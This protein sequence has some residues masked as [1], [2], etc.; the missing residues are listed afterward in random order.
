MP[1]QRRHIRGQEV[2]PP[3]AAQQQRRVLSCGDDP[4]RRVGA[5]DTQRIGSL[6]PGE[7]LVHR[8]EHVAALAIIPGQQLG[9]HL[10]IRLGHE[11]AALLDQLLLQPGEI[12]D[13]TVVHHGE[14]S[15]AA[16]LRMGVHLIGLAVSSPPGV[17]DAHCPRQIRPAV[18]QRLQRRKTPRRLAYL[19][20]V[21]AADRDT[22]GVIAPV[23]QPRKP[24]Q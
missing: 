9:H 12:L 5:Q 10:R 23:L 19:K 18:G 11:R 15:V 2:L 14:L 8:L 13:N 20:G 7:H 1:Q 24:L 22:G 4:V 3:A 16:D 17:A 21:S 6:H